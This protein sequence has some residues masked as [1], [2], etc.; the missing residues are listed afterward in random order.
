MLGITNFLLLLLHCIHSSPLGK[1]VK[2][3]INLRE[4]KKGGRDQENKIK[5]GRRGGKKKAA[6]RERTKETRRSIKGK[7]RKR[8]SRKKKRQ[9]KS[10]G[11][12]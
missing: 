4:R 10:G 2:K 3:E 11:R 6:E 1:E 5:G 8:N 9:G 7:V 12:N